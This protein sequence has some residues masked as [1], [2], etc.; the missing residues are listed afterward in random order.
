MLADSGVHQMPGIAEAFYIASRLA[1]GLLFHVDPCDRRNS[2]NARSK[3]NAY[4]K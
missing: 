4:S 2:R 3:P 1:P